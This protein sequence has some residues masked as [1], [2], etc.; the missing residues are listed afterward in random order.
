VP[1]SP[2]SNCT[3]TSSGSIKEIGRDRAE[4]FVRSTPRALRP[5]TARA[6]R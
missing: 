6:L 1:V 2:K 5:T 4:R 3:K